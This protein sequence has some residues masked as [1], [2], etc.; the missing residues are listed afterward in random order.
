MKVNDSGMICNVALVTIHHDYEFNV[1]PA[2]FNPSHYKVRTLAPRNK[3]LSVCKLPA[4]D[5]ISKKLQRVTYTFEI[6]RSINK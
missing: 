5:I 2:K 3:D 4:I 1:T 6:Q